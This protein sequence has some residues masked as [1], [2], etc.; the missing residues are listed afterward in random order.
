MNRTLITSLILI[1]F[2]LTVPACAPQPATPDDNPPNMAN[3]ASVFCE[4]HGGKV[5]NRETAAGQAGVCTFPDGSF[6]DEWAFFRGE[7][8]PGQS[9]PTAPAAVS[10]LEPAVNPA[11]WKV[12]QDDR[13]SF[14]FAYPPDTTVDTIDDP[15]KTLTVSG[16]DGWPSFSISYPSGRPEYRPPEGTDLFQWLSDNHLLG[17]NRQQDLQ[18]AG[19]TAVHL[20]HERSPQS[21]AYDRYYFAHVG[22]LYTITIGHEGDKE[23]WQVYNKFLESIQFA[24]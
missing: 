21:F 14:T 11:G 2:I 18:I 23:D 19:T 12:Y 6:C 9:A 7:C 22:Q 10:T 5:V 16:K 3:P 13:L 1:A 4:Q 15:L 8:R 17:D 24:K 20:R